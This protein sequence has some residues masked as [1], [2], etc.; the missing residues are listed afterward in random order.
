MLRIDS[1]K[2]SGLKLVMTE[3]S[4]FDVKV[5]T[6]I[7][8]KAA[9]NAFLMSNHTAVELN[10]FFIYTPVGQNMGDDTWKILGCI[11]FFGDEA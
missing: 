5:S 11:I 9:S 10:D 6:L 1:M 3:L 8:I 4:P 7:M 2:S